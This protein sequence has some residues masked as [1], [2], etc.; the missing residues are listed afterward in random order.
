MYIKKAIVLG[1]HSFLDKGIKVGIQY[2][3]EGLSQGGWD[4]DY[5]SVP[6]SPFDFYGKQR[7]IRL[8]RV[9]YGRQDTFGINI[10]NN[11]KEFAFRT[12]YPF[13]KQ[14]LRSKQLI[15]EYI[16]LAPEWI[17]T[18]KYDICIHDITA[19]ILFLP[20]IHTKH[21]VLRLNDPPNGF[22]FHMHK[23]LLKIFEDFIA[24][25]V[26]DE[27]WAVSEPLEKYAKKLNHNNNVILLPNGVEN[28]FL[29]I[30]DNEGYTKNT[31]IYIGSI[32]PWID[33]ELIKRTAQ[34]L[35]DWKFHLFGQSNNLFKNFP[36]NVKCFGPVHRKEVPELLRRYQVG[37]IPFKEQS[38]RMTY[39]E[40]PLKF[41]EYIGSGLGVASTDIGSLK[42]G[43]KNL[44]R[45]GNTP[46]D[47][48]K[49]IILAS[50]D[51]RFRTKRFN[52][53]FI[54]ENSWQSSIQ[55]MLMRINTMMRETRTKIEVVVQ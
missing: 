30:Q 14:F 27:I 37:L 40:R 15:K 7:R 23:E 22:A 45:Y 36:E 51:R 52:H 29:S 25:K 49:A 48:A 32:S 46:K 11:L 19:N 9:W 10:N 39:V 44:A 18:K 8:K 4:V 1:V 24:S 13:H 54:Q 50:K 53:L 20:L 26:Y 47:F 6:S 43:M 16:R 5:I 3:A 55:M 21:M 41:Y 42:N 28:T 35:P 34:L 33:T 12:P 17:K 31:A 2:I 38:N